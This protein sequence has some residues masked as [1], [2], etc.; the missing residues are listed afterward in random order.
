MFDSVV[1]MLF[2]DRVLSHR[3]IRRFFPCR[4]A[5]CIV[6]W[7]VFHIEPFRVQQIVYFRVS[8][9]MEHPCYS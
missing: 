3:G 2:H 7:F 8:Q 6:F 1:S 4:A 5:L 9:Y